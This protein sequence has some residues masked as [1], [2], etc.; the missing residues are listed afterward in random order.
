M[1]FI[2]ILYWK[3]ISNYKTVKNMYEYSKISDSI[4]DEY[5]KFYYL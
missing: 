5:Y 3:V 1:S 2:F 4:R